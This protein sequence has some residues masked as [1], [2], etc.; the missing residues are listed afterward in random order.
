M[1]L[2]EPCSELAP[3]IPTLIGDS[4]GA[5]M[6]GHGRAPQHVDRPRPRP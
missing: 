2:E 6:P 3:Q 4:L 1:L 5:R